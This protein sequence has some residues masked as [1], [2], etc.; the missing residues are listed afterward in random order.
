MRLKTAPLAVL[1]LIV[2]SM[3]AF[4]Q[5]DPSRPHPPRSGA[6]FYRDINFQGDFF[7]LRAGDRNATMPQGLDDGITSIRLFGNAQVRV[8]PDDNFHGVSL[9]LSRS[10]NDLRRIPV[11]DN[12][13]Q[14]WN[15]RISSIAVF[16]GRDEWAPR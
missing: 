15:D 12:R 5:W 7:C 8:F 3:P 9:L 11:S 16:R 6:C 10:M 2:T 13:R 1:L 4:A 14:N